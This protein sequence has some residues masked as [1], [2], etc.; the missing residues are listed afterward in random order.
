MLTQADMWCVPTTVIIILHTEAASVFN[1]GLDF[2][3]PF[4][5]LI[6][7][8]VNVHHVRNKAAQDRKTRQ[9]SQRKEV[10]GSTSLSLKSNGLKIRNKNFSLTSSKTQITHQCWCP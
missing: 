4:H 6:T 1:K 2:L 7:S 3:V 10:T 5:S 8:V 9:V